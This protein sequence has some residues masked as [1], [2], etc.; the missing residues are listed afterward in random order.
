MLISIV[1]PVY[2]AG[3]YLEKCINS[4]LSYKG[5]DIELILVDD[6][7]TD[8][9]ADLCDFFS[10]KDSR[11]SSYHIK[12]SGQGFARNYGIDKSSGEYLLFI[13]SDD[14]ID[15]TLIDK[16]F[17]V[18]KNC[19]PDIIFYDIS[20][21]SEKGD[22]LYYTKANLNRVRSLG[23]KDKS[24]IISTPSPCNKLFR[25]ELFNA[26]TRF[27]SDGWYEDL[28]TLLKLYYY[29]ETYYYIDESLYYYCLHDKSTM[30]NNN[31][32]KTVR[33]RKVAVND[34]YSF[35]KQKN[36]LKEYGEEIEWIL[37]FHGFFLPSREILHFDD[38]SSTLVKDLRKNIEG[39]I[40]GF[41]NNSYYKSLSQKEKVVYIFLVQ[42]L[43]VVLR[44]LLRFKKILLD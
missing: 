35:Y 17:C 37:I 26:E 31:S 16:L 2:N 44:W 40:K 11:V 39:K 33:D 30:R 23:P 32:I 14:Y 43:Q 9:S 24:V 25:R 18:L 7:S 22:L 38:Y 29:A 41:F 5:N 21:I 13:D 12:N 15:S 20:N 28:R 3:P 10:N 19:N 1:V 27:P 34:I 42:N 36:A 6:G 4:I 8:C